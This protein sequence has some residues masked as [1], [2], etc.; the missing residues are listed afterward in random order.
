VLKSLDTVPWHEL[1]HAYG[2]ADDVPGRLRDLALGSEAVRQRSIDE[3]FSSLAHQG[4]VYEASAAAVPFLAEIAV[5]QKTPLRWRVW[6]LVLLAGLANGNEFGDARYT[7]ATRAAV[8]KQLAVLLPLIDEP[9]LDLAIA[10]IAGSCGPEGSAASSR[11]EDLERTEPAG[12]RRLAFAIARGLIETGS[13][14]TAELD[15]AARLAEDFADAR[16]GT[17]PS[18]SQRALAELASSDL[19]RYLK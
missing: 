18:D 3:L 12:N 15:E 8:A 9:G 13:A 17:E 10:W 1:R 16:E 19:S 4:T 11:L 14:T 2:A 5:D 7:L 6:V